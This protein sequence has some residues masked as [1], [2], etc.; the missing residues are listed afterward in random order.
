MVWVARF[1]ILRG[2][3]LAHAVFAV[4]PSNY[5]PSNLV[6]SAELLRRS[7][8]MPE[9]KQR[10]RWLMLADPPLFRSCVAPRTTEHP[11]A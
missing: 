10:P 1:L 4:L 5:Q 2:R 7:A 11:C 3:G 8:K 9:K 6:C